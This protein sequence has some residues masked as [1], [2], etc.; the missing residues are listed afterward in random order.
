MQIDCSS[1]DYEDLL[2]DPT[3]FELNVKIGTKDWDNESAEITWIPCGYFI[4][5]ESDRTGSVLTLT[6]LDRMVLLDGQIFTTDTWGSESDT[7]TTLLNHICTSCG[8]TL[9]TDISGLSNRS[10]SFDMTKFNQLPD[11]TTYRNLLSWIAGILGK[12]AYFDWNGQLRLEGG[13]Y[14]YPVFILSKM[15]LLSLK[16]RSYDP[17]IVNKLIFTDSVEDTGGGTSNVTY[18]SAV[19]GVTYYN[20]FDLTGNELMKCNGNYQSILDAIS[21]NIEESEITTIPFEGTIGAAPFLW[22][23]DY[24][25]L[26]ITDQMSWSDRDVGYTFITNMNY[27]ING[28]TSIVAA[29][30]GD[31]SSSSSSGGSGF[32]ASQ[33]NEINV[34]NSRIDVLKAITTNT[35]TSFDGSVVSDGSITVTKKTGWC[36]VHGSLTLTDVVSDMTNVLDSTKVPTPQTGIGIYT[37]AAYWASSFTRNMRVGVGAG[38]SL[39]IQ[40]GGAGTYTF[41]IAYPIA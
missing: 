9:V 37:T 8:I 39:R 15:T 22:P 25:Y 40:Y 38:G 18:E 3:A 17:V 26:W 16:V 4:V 24:A 29:G 34:I 20:S 35:Y 28:N 36:L 6:A 31:S 21:N 2:N 5:T 30:L 10:R 19:S 12:W 11:T 33:A 14:P 13:Y 27:T 32:T 1:N 41:A 23:G 7:V